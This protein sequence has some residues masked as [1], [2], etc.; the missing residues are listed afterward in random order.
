MGDVFF[1]WSTG[2]PKEGEDSG[3]GHEYGSGPPSITMPKVQQVNQLLQTE[4]TFLCAL[5][6]RFMSHALT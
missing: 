1:I 5:I 6:T 3:D 2:G 4:V